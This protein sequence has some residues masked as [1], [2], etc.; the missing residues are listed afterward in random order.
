MTKR[1]LFIALCVAG[2]SLIFEFPAQAKHFN[3]NSTTDAVDAN[4]GDGICATATGECTLRAAI[5]ETN[6]LPGADDIFVPGAVYTITIPGDEDCGAAG[7]LDITD[8]LTVRGAGAQATVVDGGGIDRVFDVS[9]SQPGCVAGPAT[10]NVTISGMT[11]RNGNV[12]AD[13][14]TSGGGILNTQSVFLSLIDVT[15]TGNSAVFGGGVM[16]SVG[17]SAAMEGVTLSDNSAAYGAGLYTRDGGKVTVMNST[18]SGNSATG[19]G[20][21]FD[22]W[23]H[24]ALLLRNVTVAQNSAPVGAGINR[25]F[26]SKQVGLNATIVAD[27]SGGDCAG[28]IVSK[29]YNLDSDN[30]CS[31]TQPTDLP[32]RDPLLGLLQD[33]GGGTPTQALLA[34]S[35]AIDTGGTLATGCLP[36]DQRNYLRPGDGIACDIGAFENGSTTPDVAR[37]PTVAPNGKH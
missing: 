31:L 37:R 9:P 20:G 19:G 4:P 3:V 23:F 7:D 12:N 18:V 27:N 14:N 17:A 2:A 29:G 5:Q 8:D 26:N 32:G 21:G 24:A 15:V 10:P 13:Q 36:S 28:T 33:N 22:T 11:I 34:G 35:P 30:T 1:Q 16:N 25:E 6:A